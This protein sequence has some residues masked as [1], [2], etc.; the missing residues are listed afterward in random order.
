[1]ISHQSNRL[2]NRVKQRKS[3][4]K[5]L[6]FGFLLASLHTGASRALWPGLIDAA[7]QLDVNLICF[8]GGRLRAQVA[9]ESQRNVIYSLAGQGCLDGI[10]TWASSLG[11]VVG[12]TEINSFHSRYQPLPIVSLAQFMEGTPTVSV[13]SYHGMRVLLE[14]LITVS[15]LSTPGVHPRTGGA[16]LCPGALPRLPRYTPSF[17]SALETRAGYPTAP[18][19]IWC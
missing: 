8:P 7:E 5:R 3:P 15:W 18:L 12:P 4:K 6:S 19:G 9:H 1:M 11:G 10:I 17:Q 14:H 13:D 2:S 16:L